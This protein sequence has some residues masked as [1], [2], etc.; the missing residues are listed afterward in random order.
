[1]KIIQMSDPHL[2]G[3]AGDLY[4]LDPLTRLHA[5]VED[6][7][8]HHAD[9][10]LCVITG[11]LAD[12]GDRA[13]YQALR[14]VVTTL[15]M[16]CH[17]LIGNH[18]DRRVFAEVFPD[19]PRDENGYVQS[20]I[21]VRGARFVFMDTHTPAAHSG[22]YDAKRLRWLSAQL[23]QSRGEPVY[24]FMHHPPFDIGIPALD[25]IKLRNPAPL[26]A[27]MAHSAQIQHLFIG[28]VH[29]CI[30]GNW[31]GVSFSTLPSL[32]HQVPLD[33]QAVDEVPRHDGVPT[34]AVALIEHGATIVHFQEFL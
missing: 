23:A 12:R 16:P 8:T 19:T 27:V 1:M 3:H 20:S 30:S 32:H 29:R 33:F 7:K 24:L 14:D 26:A 22:C 31:N 28:H 21:D 13:A 9:A 17:L 34:Y 11:D 5:C 2:I 15:P 25:R 6:I 4:G 10:A 18:D